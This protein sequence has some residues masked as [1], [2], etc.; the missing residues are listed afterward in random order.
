LFAT[1]TERSI[2]VAAKG[3]GKKPF[4]SRWSLTARILTGY[5]VRGGK[6]RRAFRLTITT[7]VT[8][9]YYSCQGKVIKWMR[10]KEIGGS[11]EQEKGKVKPA[12]FPKTG[13]GCATHTQLLILRVLQP[14]ESRR[15]PRIYNS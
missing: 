4:D 1:L 10:G 7:Y 3:V 14:P 6:A 5:A 8:R 2:S 13:K 15:D 9:K 11:G 12:P